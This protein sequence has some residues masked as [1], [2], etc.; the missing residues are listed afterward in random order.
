MIYDSRIK[1]NTPESVILDILAN[2]PKLTTKEI[3]EYFSKKYPKKMTI[4]GFYKVV[5]NMLASR[6]LLKEGVHISLDSFWINKVIEFSKNIEKTYLEEKTS[7]GNILLNEGESKD[8]EFENIITMD[9]LWSHGLNLVRNYY[10]ANEHPDRNV[11]SRNY[12]AVFQITRAESERTNMLY[13]ESSRM[14]WHMASGSDTFLNKL[15]SKIMEEENYH[16]FIFDFELFNK[17]RK[18]PIE[19]NHWTTVIGDFIF[20]VRLPKYIFELIEKIYEDTQCIGDFNADKIYK[21]FLEPGKTFL[22]ISK[23]KKRAESIRQE[24]INLDKIKGAAKRYE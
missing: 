13:F 15:T 2:K 7:S 5:R 16:Q 11:Y 1:N 9:N 6:I 21:L 23:N 3:Y 12:Y 14:K 20:E 24:V 8:F 19:K 18:P 22:T 4:Q 10:D 17:T